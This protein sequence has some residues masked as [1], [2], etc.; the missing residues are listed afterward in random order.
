MH[1]VDRLPTDITRPRTLTP[2]SAERVVEARASPL[3]AASPSPVPSIP[4][5][6][7]DRDSATLIDLGQ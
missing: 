6:A 2:Q 1:A 4:C 5:P 7:G 3:T